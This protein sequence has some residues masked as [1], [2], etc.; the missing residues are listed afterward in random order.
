[1][2]EGG[3]WTC[4]T[5]CTPGRLATPASASPLQHACRSSLI[6]DPRPVATCAG[7]FFETSALLITFV[8]LGGWVGRRVDVAPGACSSAHVP[9]GYACPMHH[10]LLHPPVNAT[11]LSQFPLQSPCRQVSGS[12]R[13]GAHLQRHWSAAAPG[14]CHRHPLPHGRA[15]RCVGSR[16][17]VAAPQ[18]ACRRGGGCGA[19]GGQPEAPP[20]PPVCPRQPRFLL[21]LLLRPRQGHVTETE[22]VPAA[23]LQRGDRLRVLPGARLP[24]D[25]VVLEGRSHVDEALITGGCFD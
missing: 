9:P 4:G 22:E 21:L 8:C 12:C 24:V 16:R 20:V 13:K 6:G 15:G 2:G 25:G 23:L 14:A 10:W 17:W 11:L 7:L 5:L 18:A 3:A 19:L 1:M